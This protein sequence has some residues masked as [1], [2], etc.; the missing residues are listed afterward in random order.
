MGVPH[1]RLTLGRQMPA[2]DMTTVAE[3]R[4]HDD[5][6]KWKYFPRYWPFVRGIHRSPVNSSHKG[7]WHGASMFYLIYAWTNSWTNHRNADDLR[8]HRAHYDVIVMK[9]LNASGPLICHHRMPALEGLLAMTV[10]FTGKNIITRLC[11]TCTTLGLK[12]KTL[13]KYWTMVRL[14]HQRITLPE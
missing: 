7:Q 2:T 9:W 11:P 12:K 13:S 4:H 3:F 10:T 5:V 8:H 14:Y 1:R 6:I